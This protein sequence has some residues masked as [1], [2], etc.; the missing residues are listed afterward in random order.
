[1]F[2]ILPLAVRRQDANNRKEEEKRKRK[3]KDKLGR[4]DILVK[5]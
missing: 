1:M 4:S 5:I 2:P 3:K